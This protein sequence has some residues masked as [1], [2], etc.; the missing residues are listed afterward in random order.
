MSGLLFIIAAPSGTG[1]S[2]L[3]DATLKQDPSLHLSISYTTRAPR[4]WEKDGQNYHFV[5][6]ARF[7]EL[8]AQGYFTES[9]KVHGNWYGTARLWLETTM[10]QGHDILLEIDCQG[11]VA[12]KSLFKD[13]ISIFVLPPSME[14]MERRL[15]AR[16]QENEEIIQRRLRNAH[17]ELQHVVQFDYVLVN[18]VFDTAVR[19]LGMLI[20][21]S[22]LR[23]R[24]VF[25]HHPQLLTAFGIGGS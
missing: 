19:E 4:A 2:S 21:A 20:A 7:L 22:R 5:S 8:Q 6:L 15:R 12:I 13:A 16:G 25:A 23:T 3:I 18:S 24:Y 17:E 11:T 14:E 9:A 1:K 10:Q